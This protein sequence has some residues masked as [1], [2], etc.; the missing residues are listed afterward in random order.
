MN[1]KLNGQNKTPYF[2]KL[3]EY[4]ESNPTPLDVPGHKLGK[5]E[6]EMVDYTGHN[7]LS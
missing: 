4:A 1:K 6:N 3:K 7:V 2:T 5:L